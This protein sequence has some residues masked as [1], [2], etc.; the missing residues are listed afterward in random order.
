[1]A[2]R[3]QNDIVRQMRDIIT[4]LDELKTVQRVGTN[5]I[6]AKPYETAAAY[7]R[8]FAITA[9]FQ[10]VGSSFKVLRVTVSPTDFP[11]GNILISDFIPELRYTNGNRVS[12]WDFA[13][14]VMTESTF[15]FMV[16]VDPEDDTKN[17]YL[18]GIIAPTNTVMRLKV[19]ITANA[20]VSFTIEEI[21]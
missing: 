5:Q 19:H 3:D 21:N 16:Y 1:M 12:N 17:T 20:T 13:N 14:N 9:A 11:P 7:D 18:V 15:Y 10:S 4:D 8:E 2:T 6:V